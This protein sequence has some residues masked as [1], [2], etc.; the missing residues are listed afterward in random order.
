MQNHWNCDE[1]WN[2]FLEALAMQCFLL[3]Y[4]ACPTRDLTFLCT[5]FRLEYQVHTWHTPIYKP[6]Y[7]Y[8]I[9][10]KPANLQN[11]SC[12]DMLRKM[13]HFAWTSLCKLLPTT[14]GD[15]VIKQLI[16][17][18]IFKI[19]CK[20]E[21]QAWA[22]IFSQIYT[23]HQGVNSKTDLT[24]RFPTPPPRSDIFR[25]RYQLTWHGND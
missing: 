17:C 19:T 2:V 6:M 20:S 16:E 7:S 14:W 23:H 24:V 18:P 8:L 10:W 9:L 15:L 22:P 25:L 11:G 21:W 12:P 13:V 5:H 1:Q 3:L 4:C